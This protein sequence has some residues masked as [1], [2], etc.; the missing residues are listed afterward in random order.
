MKTIEEHIAE[1]QSVDKRKLAELYVPAIR[2]CVER[3][4][5][6]AVRRWLYSYEDTKW[7]A[8]LLENMTI[9]EQRE[10]DRRRLKLLEQMAIENAVLIKRE[11]AFIQEFITMLISQ[12]LGKI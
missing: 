5:W 6:D 2:R 8:D 9:S 3:V 12:L 10:E 7:Y 11:R 4:G 1:I